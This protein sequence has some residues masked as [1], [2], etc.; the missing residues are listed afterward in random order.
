MWGTFDLPENCTATISDLANSFKKTIGNELEIIEVEEGFF[1]KLF[2]KFFPKR[3]VLKKNSYTGFCL[4]FYSGK[5]F[6][7][8]YPPFLFLLPRLQT[9][10]FFFCL[11]ITVPLSAVVMVPS[12]FFFQ[13]SKIR[14]LVE[15]AFKNF[16][17]EYCGKISGEDKQSTGPKTEELISEDKKIGQKIVEMGFLTSMKVEEVLK[18]KKIDDAIGMKKPIMGYFFE[19]NLLSKEQIGEVLK[20]IESK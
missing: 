14:E 3:L 13:S 4:Y 16:T 1:Q 18:N 12:W 19:M 7:S 20:S 17:D 15:K 9:I 6:V 8:P 5:L 11:V 10:V 2:P